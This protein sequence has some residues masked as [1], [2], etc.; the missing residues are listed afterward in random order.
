[1]L[2]MTVLGQQQSYWHQL[3]FFLAGLLVSYYVLKAFRRAVFAESDS[4]VFFGVS[5]VLLPA[6]VLVSISLNFSVWDYIGYYNV[7]LSFIL[8]MTIVTCLSA[9]TGLAAVGARAIIARMKYR[10]L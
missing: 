1:M 3:P 4:R 7:V 10:R 5:L 9:V 2:D 8:L 6:I